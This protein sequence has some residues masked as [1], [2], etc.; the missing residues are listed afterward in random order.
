MVAGFGLSLQ[1]A[2]LRNVALA[3]LLVLATVLCRAG[4]KNVAPDIGYFGIL[5]PVLMFA[6]VFWGPIPAAAAAIAG[7]AAT[8]MV[9]LGAPVMTGP[10]FNPQ[11]LAV[12]A[13]I[14]PAA[15]VLW[16]AQAIRRA[17]QT[18]RAAEI[19]LR[20]SDA[21]NRATADRLHSAVQAGGLGLWEIDAA[22]RR[23][24]I[25][26]AMASMLGMEPV[27]ADMSI[28]TLSQMI[29]PADRG[30]AHATLLAALASGGAYA[31]ECRAWLTVGGERWFVTRGS[32]SADRR[33]AIG[34][35]SDITERRRREDALQAALASQ[36]QLMRARDVLMHEA[37][38]RIKNSLQL[39]VSLLQ[40]QLT[41]SENPETQH[42]VRDAMARV[43]AIATAHLALQRS[44]D[45]RTIFIDGMFETLCSQLGALNPA[46]ELTCHAGSQ[47]SLDAE[48]AI[49]LGLM[50]SELVTNALR[51]AFTPGTR[52]AVSVTV[53]VQD[54][55]L[56]VVVADGGVG[57]PAAPPDNPGLGTF[58][59]ATLAQQ[60]GADTHAHSRPGQGTVVT[61]SLPVA[62]A[63][64]L[65]E[66]A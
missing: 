53:T 1:R 44:P 19:L 25:D 32:V 40:L 28:D 3:L 61:V 60:I 58:V 9:F 36:D 35:I 65:V 10:F 17:V 29:H 37:D 62:A 16:A 30:R 2:P 24:R 42:A 39:V 54:R 26:A 5:L 48:H 38:H 13:F 64:V 21:R 49:P 41:K 63:R 56:R 34:V 57:L 8:A 31:D 66:A 45:L 11:Q 47:L 18:A 51:H 6:G 15:C 27:A 23:V 46:V 59:V 52:G 14:A 7:T 4:L 22:A 20:D 12:L 55:M 50:T 43:D 33:K